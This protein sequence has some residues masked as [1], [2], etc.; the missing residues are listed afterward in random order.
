MV[1]RA[2]RRDAKRRARP[3]LAL[4]VALLLGVPLVRP[5]TAAL[6]AQEATPVPPLP[7]LAAMSLLPTDLPEAGF[8]LESGR[9]VLLAEEAA[10]ATAYRGQAATPEAA[11]GLLE[12]LQA[13]G[14]SVTSSP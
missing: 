14:W 13:T 7:D 6:A 12:A 8:A 5:V 1:R 3:A 4:L 10:G 2:E 11:T 9:R